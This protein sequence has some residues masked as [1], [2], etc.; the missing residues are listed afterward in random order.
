MGHSQASQAQALAFWSGME[1]LASKSW[2]AASPFDYQRRKARVVPLGNKF[3]G[4]DHP[5][6]V[7]SMCTTDTM[8]TEATVA[9]SL[10][11]VKAGCELIRITAPT[12]KHSANLKPIREALW[13]AGCDL[14]IVADIHFMPD[15]AM[16]AA[17]HVEK[18]RINPGNYAD[19]KRFN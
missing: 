6:L 13:K 5:I 2:Y 10:R 17:L 8:D 1:S 16:E 12:P 9:Q 15:A 4:G 18:V 11:M 14:P 7:Q 19:T 3:V